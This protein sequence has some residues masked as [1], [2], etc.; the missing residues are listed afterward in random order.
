MRPLAGRRLGLVRP[1]RP[2]CILRNRDDQ[3]L[4]QWDAEDE[5]TA[6]WVSFEDFTSEFPNFSLEVKAGLDDPGN[7]TGWANEAGWADET[8]MDKNLWAKN[9]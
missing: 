9:R 7:D 6:S 2:L 1:R 4:V 8:P 5:S 3:L